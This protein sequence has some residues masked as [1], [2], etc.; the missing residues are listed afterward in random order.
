MIFFEISKLN[1]DFGI[2]FFR[3]QD[4]NFLTINRSILIELSELISE[5]KLDI[6]LYI[7]TRPEGINQESIKLLKKLRVDGIGMGVE[8]SSETFRQTNLNRF[9]DQDKI[10]NAFKILK[11]NGIK[12]TSY[13]II[14]APLQDEQSIKETIE[15]NRFLKPDSISV[16]YYTPYYGTKSHSDGVREGMFEDYEFDADTYLRT[17]TK[18]KDLT[19]EK[20]VYYRNK[21]IELAKDIEQSN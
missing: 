12:R 19:A 10:I 18:S 21:F 13:N 11:E 15:F 5:S 4:T 8:A 20:L 7:E 1:K 16:H 3:C 9:A 17:K 14:G 6:K 2:N